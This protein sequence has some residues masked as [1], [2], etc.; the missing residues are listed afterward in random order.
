MYVDG[1]KAAPLADN[2]D[3]SKVFNGEYT[4]AEIKAKIDAIYASAPSVVKERT[5][6]LKTAV[7]G[8]RKY[9]KLHYDSEK[10]E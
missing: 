10:R 6:K 5:T 1:V 3:A 4:A 9:I 2:V 7:E 8:A